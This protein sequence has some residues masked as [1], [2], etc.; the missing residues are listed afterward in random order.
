M[1]APARTTRPDQSERLAEQYLR[2]RGYSDV[3]YEPDGNVPPDFL[4]DGRIAVE[5]RRLNQFHESPQ[6]SKEPLEQVSEPVINWIDKCLESFGPS[7]NG[8]SWFV[9]V[10]FSRPLGDWRVVRNEL[11]GTLNEFKNSSTRRPGKS[12]VLPH[13]ELEFKKACNQHPFFFLLG[14]LSD[15][16]SGGF[17]LFE[18]YRSL[19]V[20]I[21]EKESK[22]APYRS[23]Y[24]EWWLVLI[25]HIG[26]WLNEDD[27]HQLRESP[28]VTHSLDKVVLVNPLNTSDGIEI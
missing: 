26:Y 13:L 19:E 24:P 21:P 5:V 22:I 10:S 2:A 6:G 7:V 25:N 23:G 18:T 20:I 8:E 11:R 17:T 4:V 12:C 9:H 27:A 1:D 28:P 16:D 15:Y 14:G 3:V